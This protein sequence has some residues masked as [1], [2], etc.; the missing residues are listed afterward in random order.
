MPDPQTPL[1]RALLDRILT[2]SHPTPRA[3]SSRA[4]RIAV[5][6]I[7]VILISA[8]AWA[9]VA[10]VSEPR[11][12]AC[13]EAA[14]LDGKIVVVAA[15]STLEPSVCHRLWLDGTLSNPDFDQSPPPLTGCVSPGGALLVFPGA[16]PQLCQELGLT[17][18][19][20]GEPDQNLTLNHKLL[21]YFGSTACPPLEDSIENV[22]AILRSLE[23]HE[24][25][26]EA[27]IGTGDRPCASFSLDVP[28][29]IVVLVPIPRPPTQE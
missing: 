29:K 16:D 24:W 7:T 5:A 27:G 1:G 13:Y 3:G 8:G 18:H 12:V 4:L 28:R 26:V 14:S 21:G 9:I 25:T 20:P 15:P 6:S 23:L 11:G 10:Q 17:I 19:D 2:S 22:E